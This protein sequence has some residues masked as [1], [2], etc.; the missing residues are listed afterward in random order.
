MDKGLYLSSSVFT[1]CLTP[2]SR[3]KVGGGY[4]NSCKVENLVNTPLTEEPGTR[5]QSVNP[6]S[7]VL[8]T[9]LMSSPRYGNSAESVRVS[10]PFHALWTPAT[11]LFYISF[12]IHRWLGL[13]I[14]RLTGGTLEDYFQA[15]IFGPLG[16]PPLSTF[17]PHSTEE[18][19][20]KVM[21]IRFWDEEKQEYQALVDQVDLL[22]LPRE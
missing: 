20:K 5:Y 12:R 3:T 16:L 2:E 8:M 17:Y 1:T 18:L 15:N 21:P 9:G 22:K 6:G 11:D 14:A 7:R 19:R 10:Q 13:L 4:V